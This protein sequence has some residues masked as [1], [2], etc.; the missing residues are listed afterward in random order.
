MTHEELLALLQG[1]AKSAGFRM[2]RN[3]WLVLCDV[4]ELHRPSL[5]P[6]WVPTDKEF[7]CW[8][9]HIYPCP[10]IQTIEKELL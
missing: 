5:I 4:V 8:C 9:A 10:T 7:M 1:E 6:D 2:D 3:A